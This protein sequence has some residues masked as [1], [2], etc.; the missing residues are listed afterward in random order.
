M[1]GERGTQGG[2][3]SDDVELDVDFD[4]PAV[5]A[6]FSEHLPEL[7]RSATGHRV[8]Y[9]TL[10]FASVLG[11]AAHV[12]GY[13][14]RASSPGEPLG[15]IA[16]LLYALGYALWTGVVVAL[17]VQ[18]IPDVKKRQFQQALRAYE[19]SMREHSE[20]EARNAREGGR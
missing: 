14:L 4:D 15:L 1:T 12:G 5:R 13:A 20:R 10:A 19:A 16:D 2:H 9:R 7:R 3:A 18:V 6:W 11:L 8:L 17:F